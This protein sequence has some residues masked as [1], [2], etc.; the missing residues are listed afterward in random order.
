MGLGDSLG[1]LGEEH[2]ADAAVYVGV[3]TKGVKQGLDQVTQQI[4]R[5]STRWGTAFKLAGV[6]LAGFAT[7]FIGFAIEGVKKADELDAAIARI[8]AQVGLTVPQMAQLRKGLLDMSTRVPQS[9]DQLAKSIEAV[10][11]SGYNVADSLK[12]QEAAAK[13]ATATHSDLATVTNAVVTAMKGW[14]VAAKDVGTVTDT[15]ITTVGRSRIDFDSLS[16][17]I[18]TAAPIA[19]EAGVSF[20]DLNAA[21]IAIGRSGLPARRAASGVLTLIRSLTSPAAQKE[22]QALGLHIDAT[23]IAHKGLLATLQE[24][25]KVAGKHLDV[26][27]RNK[28]GHIDWAKS[29]AATTKANTGGMHEMQVMTGGAA[30]LITANILLSNGAKDYKSAQDAL[31]HS[32]GKTNEEFKAVVE[33]DLGLQLDKIKN[34]ITSLAIG[35][36]TDLLPYVAKFVG[37]LADELPKALQGIGLLWD[38]YLKGPVTAMVTSFLGM[39]DAVAKVLFGATAGAGGKSPVITFFETLASILGNVAKDLGGVFDVIKNILQLPFMNEIATLLKVGAAISLLATG[40][41]AL[42]KLLTGK[43]LGGLNFATGGIF[44][45]GQTGGGGPKTP[46]DESAAKTTEA[47]A[48]LTEAAVKHGEA[49]A[50]TS[51]AAAKTGEAA[52]KLDEAAIKMGERGL[53]GGGV[54]GLAAAETAINVPEAIRNQTYIESTIAANEATIK[55]SEAS[56]VASK[57]STAADDSS[58]KTDE[59]VDKTMATTAATMDG[60]G[61]S[62]KLQGEAAAAIKQAQDAS[63]AVTEEGQAAQVAAV[64][65][66]QAAQVMAAREGAGAGALGGLRAK[67]G[68]AL[69]AAGGLIGG[70]ISKAIVPLLVAQLASEIIKGPV[71]SVVAGIPGFERA[72]ERIKSDFIG[73]LLDVFTKSMQGAD[74][75]V[76]FKDKTTIGKVTLDTVKLAQLGI[77]SATIANLQ[78]DNPVTVAVADIQNLQ[79]PLAEGA[80]KKVGES[81]LAWVT[82]VRATMTL[83]PEVSAQIDGILAARPSQFHGGHGGGVTTFGA[84]T[85]A[86]EDALTKLLTGG[87]RGTIDSLAGASK[88]VLTKAITEATT[89]TFTPGQISQL[90]AAQLATIQSLMTADTQSQ[91]VGLRDFLLNKWLRGTEVP[92]TPVRTSGTGNRLVPTK[93]PGVF[94]DVPTPL[95]GPHKGT[96]QSGIDR[97]ALGKDESMVQ[98]AIKNYLDTIPPEVQSA[99]KDW[100]EKLAT[101]DPA[102]QAALVKKFGADWKYTSTA[103]IIALPDKDPISK[104]LA[105]TFGSKWRQ[106]M[107]DA[108]PLLLQSVGG[109]DFL[110][111]KVALARAIATTIGSLKPGDIAVTGT[112]GGVITGDITSNPKDTKKAQ[113]QITDTINSV[114]FQ[115][116][117]AA[118]TSPDATQAKKGFDDMGKALSASIPDAGK[119]AAFIGVL[120]SLQKAG[121][122]PYGNFQ[123]AVDTFLKASGVGNGLTDVANGIDALS[124]ALSRFAAAHPE[125]VAQITTGPGPHHSATNKGN[126]TASGGIISANQ[127]TSLTFGEAGGETAIVLRAPH[128]A[129][130]QGLMSGLA[131]GRPAPGGLSVAGAGG[132]RGGGMTLNVDTMHVQ[133]AADETAILDTL[134]FMAPAGV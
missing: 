96:D 115:A 67:A 108:G 120:S 44:R 89:G 6:G 20:G 66:G 23:T 68:S 118:S 123:T 84:L 24:M 105:A 110:S 45:I 83:P 87:V 76:G 97:R 7:A 111:L 54:T 63:L 77:D 46:I 8:G 50:K 78:S 109:Q 3:N 95:G 40:L 114:T 47:A 36:G 49:A 125:W 38:T 104:G 33:A 101:V 5:G 116:A 70:L 32:L 124:G 48:K 61:A 60:V 64:R 100:T 79:A 29:I 2:L 57:D 99:L 133:S 74:A 56:Q 27:V 112:S 128:T 39:A 53:V 122:A 11:K 75:A 117:L 41:P 21:I 88:D 1:Q 129:S 119:R 69:G 106:Y 30:G 127:P 107:K 59:V 31:N 82:R 37:F 86:Q 90:D 65:E 4:E 12:I 102:T 103:A 13:V 72:G 131:G 91:Y 9:F 15:L 113:K 94:L 26:I 51:E 132:G 52:L 73:G 35:I 71:G 55:A 121:S 130:L 92:T 85:P 80:R 134:E 10:A 17:I 42:A 98:G 22:M 62:A 93:V 81:V 19:K 14:N 34:R 18:A 58:I 28:K 126:A 16:R 43:L 25:S